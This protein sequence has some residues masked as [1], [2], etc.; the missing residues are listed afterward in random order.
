M[1]LDEDIGRDLEKRIID[2]LKGG[3]CVFEYCQSVA[4]V[5][6]GEENFL[7]YAPRFVALIKTNFSN[8]KIWKS[9]NDGNQNGNNC[10]DSPDNMMRIVCKLSVEFNEM[11]HGLHEASKS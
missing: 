3:L 8:K 7:N 11:L 4:K 1:L 6:L 2:Q 5:F 9:K 10:H